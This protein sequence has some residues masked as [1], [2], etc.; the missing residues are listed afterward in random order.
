MRECA[1]DAIAS[2]W[3]DFCRLGLSAQPFDGFTR[4]QLDELITR[5]LIGPGSIELGSVV[6]T[7]G[8]QSARGWT[9]EL[10]EAANGLD[11]EGLRRA[12]ADADDAL[13]GLAVLVLLCLWTP[14]AEAA[15]P[16]WTAVA[17]VDGEHQPGLRRLARIV[18]RQLATEPTVAELLRWFVRTFVVAIHETV[19]TS[20]LP[21]ST[22]RFYW[23]HGRLRFVDNGIWRFYPS[24]LRRDA[25]ATIAFY[26]G[27]WHVD[28]AEVPSLTAVGR[29]SRRCSV[30][31]A[32]G[33]LQRRRHHVLGADR[34]ARP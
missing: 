5:S 24:G 16:A 32:G 9:A 4:S 29:W 23:E 7:T 6:V 17:G 22:F 20:K 10:E 21:V 8:D 3:H 14:K 18:T 13:T 33:L 11:W 2:I 15:G 27:W 30:R 31:E 34:R 12:A 1:Q 26:L 25:L 28:D 19:A